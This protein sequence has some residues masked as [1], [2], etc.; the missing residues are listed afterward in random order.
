MSAY[1]A[2]GGA[3]STI[4]QGGF[5]DATLSSLLQLRVPTATSTS[6]SSSPSATNTS[7][8]QSGNGKT[9]KQSSSTNTGAIAG[10]VVGGVVGLALLACIA[11]FL[12][13]RNRQSKHMMPLQQSS[14]KQHLPPQPLQEMEG[15]GRQYEMDGSALHELPAVAER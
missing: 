8:S 10:G 9:G 15:R 14:E 2:S 1:S 4:P 3:T 5:A 13:R 12:I 6:T 7:S 11:W